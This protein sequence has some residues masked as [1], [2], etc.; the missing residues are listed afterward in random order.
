MIQEALLII[1]YTNDFVDSNGSLTLG[2]PA[3]ELESHIIKLADQFLKENK[4][5]ILPTDL[6]YKNNPY[7]PETQLFPAHNLPNTWGR[8]FYRKLQD[9]Y[10]KNKTEEHVVSMDKTRYSSFAGTNLDLFLRERQ[11]DTLHLTGVSTDICILHT[12]IDAYNRCYKLIVHKNC[13]ASLTNE[14]QAWALNH[15]KTCLGAKVIE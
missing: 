6:H 15:F 4:W 3:Q 1:D 8:K 10:D 12:A 2:K 11:I 5:V 9:W 14:G 7:H 13:V